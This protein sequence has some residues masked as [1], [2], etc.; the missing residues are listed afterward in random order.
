MLDLSHLD[1]GTAPFTLTEVD[2]EEIVEG[3]MA[4]GHALARGRQVRL[5]QDLPEALPTLHTDGQ[6]LRQV[7]LALLT[8]AIKFTQEGDVLLRVTRDDGQVTISVSDS[9]GGIPQAEQAHIFADAPRNQGGDSEDEP[10]FGLAISKR[11]VERLGG[12]ILAGKQTGRR[13]DLYL[14]IAHRVR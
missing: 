7:I 12:K 5:H 1:I 4:T 9:S 10:G 8:N 11:V 6:R 14:L 3:V 2:L 13:S